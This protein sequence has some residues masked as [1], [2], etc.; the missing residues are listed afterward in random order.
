LSRGDDT[1]FLAEKLEGKWGE[2]AEIVDSQ[3]VPLRK[4]MDNVCWVVWAEG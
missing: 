2:E 1:L 3:S 4:E